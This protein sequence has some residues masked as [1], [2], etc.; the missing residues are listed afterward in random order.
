MD[1][2][3]APLIEVFSAA[4]APVDEY[5]APLFE[6]FSAAP[7]PV[8]EYVARFPWL[9]WTSRWSSAAPA[10]VD[11]YVAPLAPVDEYVAPLRHLLPW[12]SRC[13]GDRRLHGEVAELVSNAEDH[14]GD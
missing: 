7:A 12:T 13:R 14:A 3:V 9:P 6:V 1:E 11:E 4:P 10:P 8:D 5:V 2:Y